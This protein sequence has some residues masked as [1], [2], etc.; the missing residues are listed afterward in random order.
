M[1]VTVDIKLNEIGKGSGNYSVNAIFTDDT[2]PT[3]EQETI[4]NDIQSARVDTPEQKKHLW[5]E[6]K[7]LYDDK[8]VAVVRPTADVEAEG[9][10]YLEKEI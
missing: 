4:V 1:A 2:K 10:A 6:L 7:K 8:L 5:D 3:D 9:K